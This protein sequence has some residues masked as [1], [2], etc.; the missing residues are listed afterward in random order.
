MLA[1]KVYDGGNM[2]AATLQAVV[3]NPFV[4]TALP[5]MFTVLLA[6]WMNNKGFDGIHKGMDGLH[7]R[8]DDMRSDFSRQFAQIDKRFDRIEDRLERIEAKIDSHETRI[9]RLEERSS[10][11][12]RR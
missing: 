6:V 4:T 7:K 5:I 10:P 3:N 9:V 2:N 11:L 1:G 12:T 8:L